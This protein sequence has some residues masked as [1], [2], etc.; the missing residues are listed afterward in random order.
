M[1]KTIVTAMLITAFVIAFL[2]V[3]GRGGETEGTIPFRMVGHM[4]LVT[5]K[6]DDSPNEYNFIVDTGGATFVAKDVA[7]DLGLKQMGPQAKISTLHLPGFP[8]E[9][10]FCFTTFDFSLFK[11]LG[12]PIHGIIGSS[13]L[14]RFKVTLDYKAGTIMLSQDT[15]QLEK[16]DRGMLLKFRNHP[17]N[18]A[19]LVEMEV[20]GKAVEAMIDTGQPYPLVIP[21][22]TFEEYG[23]DDFDGCIK[24]KGLMEK[25]PST[26]VDFNY[27]VR[28]KKVQ[29]GGS[30]FPN[31]LC[32][33]GDLP[34]VLSMPLVGSDFLSQFV[35]VINFPGD[36]MQMVPH[37][38]FHLKNN[39]FSVG[40][41]VELSEKEEVLVEGIWEKSPAEKA[42]ILAGDRIVSFNSKAVGP[43][44]M[45]ELQNALRDDNIK[46]LNLEL[47][48]GGQEKRLVLEKALLF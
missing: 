16:P 14:E 5:A 43:D 15:R 38:D 31:F 10:V 7:E 44:N 39:L 32:L 13:L 25:W 47:I 26:K 17:V 35:L 1:K 45:L 36:E 21:I 37:D 3:P 40:I 27:L 20:N 12:I 48:S 11:A 33:F 29:M 41:N 4:I 23:R 18:N 24:S 19:P 2:S 46:S 6:I 42:G 8:I 30:A 22:E 34:K 9:N 28:L